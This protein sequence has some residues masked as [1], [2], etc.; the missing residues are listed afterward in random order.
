M[1]LPS[2]TRET[3]SKLLAVAVLA[4]SVAVAGWAESPSGSASEA[5]GP[6]P[7]S[8]ERLAAHRL[9]R[10][11][12]RLGL[13]TFPD[14]SGL[15]TARLA[16]ALEYR[17]HHPGA[18][19]IFAR[20]LTARLANE[21][22][23]LGVGRALDPPPAAEPA[24]RATEPRSEA[25]TERVRRILE[26]V[27][28]LEEKLDLWAR[29]PE[30]AAG[31][32]V[33]RSAPAN[34]DCTAATSI[35]LGTVSGSTASAT[36]DGSATCGGSDGAPDVW[37]RFAAPAAGVF[38]FDTFGSSFDTVLSL[39]TGC[40][41]DG[42]GQELA[43]DDD[44][45]GTAQSAVTLELDA[46]QEVRI[47]VAGS[48]EA[49]GSF[50][51]NVQQ[52]NGIA[53]TVSR[54]DTGAPVA[55]GTVELYNATNTLVD[56]VVTGGD[57]RYLFGD[58]QTGLAYY[59][60]AEANGLVR[61][62]YQD[63]PCPFSTTCNPAEDGTA[64]EW[65]SGL[66]FD[67]DLALAPAGALSGAVTDAGTGDPLSAFLDL[68][69]NAGTFLDSVA[70]GPDGSYE[71]ADLPAG[72]YYLSAEAADH[73]SEVY[74]D[75]PCDGSCD[76]TVGSPL[77]VS[78]GHTLSGIDFALDEPGAISGTVTVD[79]SGDP[80]SGGNVSVY[81]ESGSFV[82]SAYT[83]TDG[84]Y[85]VGALPGGSYFVRAS[86][87][88][89]TYE[90]TYQP[91]IY[92]DVPCPNT[93][94]VTAGTPV[95]VSYNGTTSGIDFAL[96][97]LGTISG[98]VTDASS[99]AP[100]SGARLDAYNPFNSLTGSAL[101][102]VNGQY[103]LVA[104]PSDDYTV[105][106]VSDSHRD[107]VYDDMPC[108]PSC[109]PKAGDP[110]GVTAGTSTTG[111]DF[112]LTPYGTIS[113]IVTEALTGD[114]LFY[115]RI[116]V[117]ASFTNTA[118]DGSYRLTLPP[119]AYHL[120]TF[121]YSGYHRDEV[122]D[123]VP[124]QPDCD[125]SSGTPI[126][127]PLDTAVS[128]IDFALDSYGVIRGKV[129]E[130]GTGAPGADF[131][132]AEPTAGGEEEG[133]TV[134]APSGDY[135]IRG[136]HPGTYVVRTGEVS[137]AGVPPHQDE[138]FDNV[139]CEPSCDLS[140]GVQIPIALN[141]TVLGV[142]FVV[143]RCPAES[144]DE[145]LA[146][147]YQGTSTEQACERVTAGGGTTIASGADVTFEAGRSVVLGDGFSVESGASFRVVIEPSWTTDE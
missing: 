85:R 127:V 126:E 103:T 128:G 112:Q 88:N 54:E 84:S 20:H 141:A 79:P 74:D 144:Y 11:D 1:Q 147:R 12:E 70:T 40:P 97:R 107:E 130:A 18:T 27:Q 32:L 6:P 33:P 110:I 98:T 57:G 105:V 146:T 116:E 39:Y 123:D 60:V 65:S 118:A 69:S 145:I 53:G 121:D 138:L 119:G 59:V 86:G 100:V 89:L 41:Q 25:R 122:W 67:V 38:T 30:R 75:L 129:V 143:A 114:P 71:L 91:E 37:F 49:A 64:I 7:G 125:L 140:Q 95:T 44:S 124:C 82:A 80:V 101:T 99:G 96:L 87:N 115:V 5:Q 31:S 35:G 62:L 52:P 83:Q 68:Y 76:V 50:Q 78:T 22:R 135:A 4:W 56:E 137:Y 2:R 29:S 19:G 133:G 93:C 134:L 92:D 42:R 14:G 63:V 90:T 77:L 17:L 13:G 45:E 61:E 94:D 102:D 104:L 142:D 3:C 139:P 10:L 47:R 72:T 117:G 66:V 28:R 131:A 26:I 58:L 36:A 34:D 108:G 55:G 132:L 43:C 120:R 21:L 81:D 109:D 136:L 23:R 8:L 24:Q 48:G 16:A 113:G 15:W 73:R 51:L 111:I 106:A 46:G 9:A